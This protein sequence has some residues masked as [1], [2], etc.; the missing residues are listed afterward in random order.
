[1]LGGHSLLAT[2][3]IGR[4]RTELG[5]DIPIRTVFRTPTVA[6][7]AERSQELAATSRPRLRKMTVEE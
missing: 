2:R 4:I 7:L 5:I 1:A 3:L 6:Q